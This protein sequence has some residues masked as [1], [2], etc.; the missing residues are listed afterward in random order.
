MPELPEVQTIVNELSETVTQKLI[1]SCK[2]LRESVIQGDSDYFSR[3]LLGRTI[4]KVSRKGKYIIFTLSGKM[5][6]IVHLSMTGKF[7]LKTKKE[8]SHKHDRVVFNLNS[9]QRLIFNDLR[10]FGKLEL[11]NRLDIHPGIL[12][13]GWEPWD[14]NLSAKNFRNRVKSRSTSIKAILMD[15]T[16]IAGL[17]NIYVSEILFEA[18]INPVVSINTLKTQQISR[19]LSSVRKI[20]AFAI[21]LNGTSISDYRRVDDKQGKF[22]NFLKVYGKEGQSC[23]T[24][25]SKIVKIK[26]NQR[27]TFLCPTCQKLLPVA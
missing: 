22:Q 10:C 18:A 25:S 3:A 15:Q 16:V 20:L 27:S 12:K 19:L 23:V 9:G 21:Q 17:G 11:I 6:M 2:I 24:C 13:L 8:K 1:E 26:Q 7:V 4:M 5:W 14:K